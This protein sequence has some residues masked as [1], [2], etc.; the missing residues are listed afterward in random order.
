MAAAIIA[1]IKRMNYHSR[2]RRSP[3]PILFLATLAFHFSAHRSH[4][5]ASEPNETYATAS[6]GTPLHW[7]VYTP[8]GSGPW[9]A[10]L[11]IHGGGFTGGAPTSAPESVTCGRDLA[12]AGFI[13]FS[14][15]YRLAPL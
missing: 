12:A 7:V 9:P 2:S 6:D 11:V 8:A 1:I 13:A 5:V 3:L 15:E 14:I 10:V 4:A